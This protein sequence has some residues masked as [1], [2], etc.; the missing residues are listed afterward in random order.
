M[1]RKRRKSQSCHPRNEMG[2]RLAGFGLSM[3]LITFLTLE[4][5]MPTVK[6]ANII[7]NFGGTCGLTPLVGAFIADAYLGRFKTIAITSIIYMLGVVLLTLSAAFSSL[8]P[9]SCNYHMGVSSLICKEPSSK[10]LWYFFS[11]L[12]L[13]AVGT[14]GIRPNT[15]PFGADQFD[16]SHP[17]EKNQLWHFFNWY[18]FCVGISILGALTVIVWVQDNVG[19]TWGFGIP[20]GAMA[21]A[22]LSF[23]IGAPFFRY[24]PPVGSPFTR[25]AQ[26]IVASYRKRKLSLPSDTSLLHRRNDK[27]ELINYPAVIELH[28]SNQFTLLDKAAIVEEDNNMSSHASRWRLCTVHQIEELKS[29]LR[30]APIWMTTIL[31]STVIVQQ[32]TFS[33][34]Q[35]RTMNRWMG[36]NFQMPAASFG[37]FGILMLLTWVPIYDLYVMGWLKKVTGNERGVTP[38]QRIGAGLF[39]AI[40]SMVAA[41]AVEVKRRN[42]AHR[43]GL[44]DRPDLTVPISA[45]WLVPQHCLFGLAESFV[46]IGELE[47]F[48]DQSPESMR[49]T[50]TALF[51]S[52]F[53][54]G[55]Y[56]STALVTLIDHNTNWLENNLNRAHLDHF[57]WFLAV[58]ST[59]NLLFFLLSA[60]WFR[61]R[62][63]G[64]DPDLDIHLETSAALKPN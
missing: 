4:M 25:I 61:Y 38:L 16:P 7:T 63:E 8:R 42:V 12:F 32:G 56:V 50:G 43:H 52:T 27:G 31:V 40:L 44:L 33:V 49:S 3:N 23:F 17:K 18:Y 57:Y 28:H 30:M 26:V 51:W 21:I 58:L 37:V 22:L 62:N 36:Y 39:I 14:G 1:W 60:H 55:N 59:V 24:M 47:F 6:A 15:A 45:F 48:Y 11:S 13:L 19:W 20:A 5:H 35:A 53:A 2:E 10:Q 34:Q 46:F 64:L 41:A 54:L 9:P 29:L